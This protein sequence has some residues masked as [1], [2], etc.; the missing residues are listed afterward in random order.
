MLYSPTQVEFL[1]EDGID[2]YRKKW[3]EEGVSPVIATILMV[4]IT[5][6]LAAVLYVMVIGFGGSGTQTPAGVITATSITDAKNQKFTF[7]QFNPDAKWA[8]LKLLVD[9]GTT[10]WGFTMTHTA[11][12]LNFTLAT[13]ATP[14]M[15]PSGSDLAGDNKVSAGDYISIRINGN[16]F[17]TG[18]TY[19][20][21]ILYI[22]TGNKVCEKAFSR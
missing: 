18:Q 9:D 13:G 17:T 11:G 4:A 7:S 5:V 10:T 22:P 6:V 19:K 16:G 12:T 14:T 8:D 20:V 3:T 2:M 15:F 21:Q 1:Q